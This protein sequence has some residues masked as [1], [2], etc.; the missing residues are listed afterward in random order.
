ML[1]DR[2]AA[3]TYRRLMELA[4]HRF[5]GGEGE[6]L[7]GIRAAM[8]YL[9]YTVADRPVWEAEF[10]RVSHGGR[11]EVDLFVR[12]LLDEQLILFEQALRGV[13]PPDADDHP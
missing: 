3:M 1:Y 2:L 5:N 9:S 7:H 6:R 8:E 10:L 4:T 12:E 11:D 13:S